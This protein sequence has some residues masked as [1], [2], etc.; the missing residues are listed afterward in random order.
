MED[1]RTKFARRSNIH[2]KDV[3]AAFARRSDIRGEDD[4]DKFWGEVF[5]NVHNGEWAL[6]IVCTNMKE[7]W[8]G[9]LYKCVR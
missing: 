6:L 1:G 8:S 2:G 5:V 3:Q 4:T 7:K 9:C